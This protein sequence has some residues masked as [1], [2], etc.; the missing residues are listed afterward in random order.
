[1]SIYYQCRF[2][3]LVLDLSK[4]PDIIE[5]LKFNKELDYGSLEDKITVPEFKDI[6]YSEIYYN[7]FTDDLEFIFILEPTDTVKLNICFGNKNRDGSME[8]IIRTLLKYYVSGKIYFDNERLVREV[9]IKKTILDVEDVV[10]RPIEESYQELLIANDIDAI[11]PDS[12]YGTI[13]LDK[14]LEDMLYIDI[15]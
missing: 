11:E 4:R 9:N 7:S 8:T 14:A 3:D 6:Q 15:S 13:E 12:F 5:W 10:F 1:M 2:K